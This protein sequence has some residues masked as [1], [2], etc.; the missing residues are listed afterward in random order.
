MF[1]QLWSLAFLPWM[2]WLLTERAKDKG[3]LGTLC[4]IVLIF[5]AT[6]DAPWTVNNI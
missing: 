2:A 3:A 4:N 6:N 5:Q 1:P